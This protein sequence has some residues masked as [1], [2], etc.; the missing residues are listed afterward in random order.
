MTGIGGGEVGDQGK[1]TVENLDL[2]K[3]ESFEII[4]DENG[5]ANSSGKKNPKV[6][7]TNDKGEDEEDEEIDEDD[8]LAIRN[9]R[10]KEKNKNVPTAFE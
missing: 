8:I 10:L 2:Q 4:Q 3:Q 5:G 7:V 6:S 9:R 1:K